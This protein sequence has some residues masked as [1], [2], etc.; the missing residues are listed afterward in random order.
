MAKEMIKRPNCYDCIHCH[1]TDHL[2]ALSCLN[3]NA[4]AK[5]DYKRSQWPFR[6]WDV[7]S[8][9]GFSLKPKTNEPDKKD[10]SDELTVELFGNTN[11]FNIQ[12][13]GRMLAGKYPNEDRMDYKKAS[14]VISKK[15]LLTILNCG[16]N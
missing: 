13:N 1:K 3:E 9:N 8:C 6:F 12:I 5:W 15:K 2:T 14:I 11:G 16:E 10:Y 7:Y 4:Y